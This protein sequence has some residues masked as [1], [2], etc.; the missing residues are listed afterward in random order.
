MDVVLLPIQQRFP[1]RSPPQSQFQSETARQ[2]LAQCAEKIGAPL[3]GWEKDEN[4]VPKPLGKYQWSVTHKQHWCAA[5]I[6]EQKVGVDIEAVAPRRKFHYQALGNSSEWNLLGE[7]NIHTFFRL[8]T[9]KEAVL[10]ANGSGIGHLMDCHLESI[11]DPRHMSLSFENQLW[12][13]E[14]FHFDNHIAAVTCC[15]HSVA[16]SIESVR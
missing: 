5:V 2:A 8:W 12:R 13:V 14:H 11:K 9:A 3:I 1:Y 4:N 6:A 7:Q 10:K 16:W 15:D